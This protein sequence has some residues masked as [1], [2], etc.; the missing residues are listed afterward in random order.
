M[1]AVNFVD[2]VMRMSGK[3]LEAADEKSESLPDLGDLKTS[4]SES[5]NQIGPDKM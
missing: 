3:Q 5:L 1:K 4:F 2:K